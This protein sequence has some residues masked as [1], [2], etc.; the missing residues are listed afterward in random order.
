MVGRRGRFRYIRRRISYG[1][2]ETIEKI[3]KTKGK[4]AS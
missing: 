1:Y 4:A 3:T 2:E